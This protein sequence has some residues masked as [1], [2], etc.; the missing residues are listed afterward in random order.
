MIERTFFFQD[1]LKWSEGAISEK[2]DIPAY[3]L[4]KIPLA[5]KVER[6]NRSDDRKGID[7]WVTLQSGRIVG[8]D[9][10]VRAEDWAPKGHDD[11]ALETWSVYE[12]QVIGWTRDPSKQTDYILFLWKDTGRCMLLS[13]PELCSIFIE[14]W[15]AWR[16]KYKPYVQKSENFSQWHSECV[17]VPRVQIWK[18]LYAAFGGVPS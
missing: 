4:R 11:V 12:K 17:F 13:F 16:K 8:V 3:L 1:Q 14:Q 10:K 9:V 5:V 15:E 7:Y 6:A 18:K 2:E